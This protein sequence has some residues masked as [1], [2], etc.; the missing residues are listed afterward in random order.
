M[1]SLKNDSIP[2]VLSADVPSQK[3]PL[4]EVALTELDEVVETI[5]ACLDGGRYD[6]NDESELRSSLRFF[7]EW[8]EERSSELGR[9]AIACA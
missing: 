3:F 6:P 5:E 4:R 2:A 1:E 9:A 7:L 8:R